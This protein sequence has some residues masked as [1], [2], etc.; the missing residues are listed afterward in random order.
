MPASGSGAHRSQVSALAG[1]MQAQVGAQVMQVEAQ[2]AALAAAGAGAPPAAGPVAG[3]V[4]AGTSLMP[5]GVK[6]ELPKYSG[7][8]DAQSLTV[9]LTKFTAVLRL[10]GY[11]GSEAD[12]VQLCAYCLTG[13]AETWLTT[14]LKAHAGASPS[15]WAEWETLLEATFA[16]L[17]RKVIARNRVDALLL[18]GGRNQPQT[19][20]EMVQRFSELR[21]EL[22]EELPNDGA[23]TLCCFT[24]ALS[25]DADL[26]MEVMKTKPKTWEEAAKEATELVN[27]RRTLQANLQAFRRGGMQ[28]PPVG[29]GGGVSSS[30]RSAGQYQGPMAMELGA[31]GLRREG[32]RPERPNPN[33]GLGGHSGGRFGGRGGGRFG[34]GG[35]RG[36]F[37]S[38]PDRSR[39]ELSCFRCGQAGH[40]ARNCPLQGSQQPQQQN[41]SWS[42][43]QG[44]CF[45]CGQPG[46]WRRD[47]PNGRA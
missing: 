9:F 43:G 34:R 27:A 16:P 2:L 1:T 11:A 7:R 45:Q 38:R 14:Y 18:R 8:R 17:D 36:G 26:Y 19:V 24:K 28:R 15:T 4:A 6:A 3:G 40:L 47:C 25:S 31:M 21:L 30:G 37:S 32:L 29:G 46:H 10:I 20:S 23:E 13:Q 44:V 41:N 42:G 22:A 35:G 12:Q 39:I 33:N 5:K